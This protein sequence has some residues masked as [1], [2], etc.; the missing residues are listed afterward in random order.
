MRQNTDDPVSEVTPI[1]DAGSPQTAIWQ[2]RNRFSGNTRRRHDCSAV[3]RPRAV[4]A[5]RRRAGRITETPVEIIT[6]QL[7][8]S[9]ASEQFPLR[10]RQT[11][12]EGNDA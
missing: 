5:R 11:T 9:R 10:V 2:R 12:F 3:V 8:R 7:V 1:L 6:S 4:L